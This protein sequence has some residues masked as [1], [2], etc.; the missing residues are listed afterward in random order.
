MIN[1]ELMTHSYAYSDSHVDI[2]GDSEGKVNNLGGDITG[3]FEKKVNLNMCLI[4]KS[5][6]NRTVWISRPNFFRFLFV[7][8]DEQQS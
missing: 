1:A 3:N 4:V 5:Y 8:L 7:G 6:R 2:Q